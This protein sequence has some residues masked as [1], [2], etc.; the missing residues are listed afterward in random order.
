MVMDI[1]LTAFLSL[2]DLGKTA[3]ST[4]IV[5][6]PYNTPILPCKQEKQ[7]QKYHFT[8]GLLADSHLHMISYQPSMA[9]SCSGHYKRCS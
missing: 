6:N 8:E 7:P 2:N 9:L 5:F 4:D 3:I 1:Y